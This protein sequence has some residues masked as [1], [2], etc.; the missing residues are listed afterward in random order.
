M[1]RRPA[2]DKEYFEELRKL[3]EASDNVEEYNV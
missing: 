2:M 3:Y 1:Q